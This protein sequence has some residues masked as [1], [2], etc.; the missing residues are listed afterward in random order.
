MKNIINDNIEIIHCGINLNLF[1]SNHDKKPIKGRLNIMTVGS[2][3]SKKGHDYLIRACIILNQK[4]ISFHCYIIGEGRARPHLERLIKANNLDNKIFLCGA[5][6]REEVIK[7]YKSSNVFVLASVQSKS[8]DMDGIP[9]VLMEAA[10]MQVPIVSTRVAGIPELVKNNYTGI[11][12][13]PADEMGIADAILRIRNSAIL[14]TNIIENAYNI[15][16]EQFN[17]K[18]NV[19]KLHRL[20]ADCVISNNIGKI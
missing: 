3:I 20:Q 2:L 5:L 1:D 18:N 7:F 4:G 19:E 11:L 16:Q 17:I 6:R 8:G 14:R 12:V 13:K 15:V 10:A 9:V